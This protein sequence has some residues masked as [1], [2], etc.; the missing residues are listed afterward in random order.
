MHTIM[1]IM[2]WNTYKNISINQTVC[3]IAKE[4]NIDIVFLA[5]Y[6]DDIQI[7]ADNLGMHSY[8][9]LGCDRIK[10]IG[11]VKSVEP[12]A[13]GYRHSIQIIENRYIICAIHLPSQ[14]S[15]GHQGRRNIVI[16][17]ILKDI[18][19]I[20]KKLNSK[21]SIILGDFNE[22]PYE[23]GCLSA[24]NFHGLPF[25][26]DFSKA[27]RVIEG[28][29]FEMFYNPMWNLFGD[30]NTPPGTYYYAGGNPRCS[31]WHIFD[32]VMIR[33]CLKSEFVK[34]SLEIVTKVGER[35]LLNE[36][37]YPNKEY[38]DHLPIVFEIQEG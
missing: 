20:E 27:Y 17:T 33:A 30:F 18:Q 36:K 19:D 11:R 26:N 32:Q 22:D 35:T 23:D 37:G 15:D 10:V 4:K 29:Q 6:Q 13:Q 34:N 16:Q 9:T 28:Q 1:R 2:F 21:R 3:E 38:S 24:V 5:E 12:G 31:Y 25:I 7:L 8:V 14:M